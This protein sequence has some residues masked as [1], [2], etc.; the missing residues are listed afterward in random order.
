MVSV[1]AIRC[2]AVLA[3]ITC[4]A[5]L[6]CGA[7]RAGI[8]GAP[9]QQGSVVLVTHRDSTDH[10]SASAV[11]AGDRSYRWVHLGTRRLYVQGSSVLP[12]WSPRHLALVDEAVRAWMQADGVRIELVSWPVEADVRLYWT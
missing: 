4:F 2:R 3:A 11:T 6:S 5:A 10:T 9:I 8:I 12:G 7:P 1:R